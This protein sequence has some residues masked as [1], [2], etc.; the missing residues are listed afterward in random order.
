MNAEV[1]GANSMQ[2]LGLMSGTSLD[3]VD[4]ALLE[5]D[6]ESICAIG[7]SGEKKLPATL[8]N[9]CFAAMRIARSPDGH[10]SRERFADLDRAIAEFQAAAVSDF[11]AHNGIGP[12]PVAAVGFH[13]QTILHRPA[14]AGAIGETLQ[15]GSAQVLADLIEIPVVYDLRAA[16]IAAG[17]QGAPLAPV[18]HAA[19]VR[20]SSLPLPVA[21][22][23]L[24][25]VA[26]V[27]WIGAQGELFA[28]DT[29][30]ANGPLDQLT[31][32]HGL[33]RF[34][35]DGH[36]AASGKVDEDRI[37]G[38]LT[39]SYFAA[40]VPK[41]LD[42][43]DFSSD[44]VRDLSPPDGA[45]TLAAFAAAA[46]AHAL[47]LAPEMPAKLVVT[48]GG[49]YNPVIMEQLVERTTVPVIRAED[50][51]WLG[52]AIEAQ[53]WAFLAARHIR[54]LPITFPGT[55]GVRRPLSGGRLAVP[56]AAE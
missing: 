10:Y 12:A 8:R 36:L 32:G 4:I 6:G 39:H 33:G 46:V 23:N 31:L 20:W 22:L 55:T 13:G 51:G 25:G 30:P 2:V 41:S 40:F 54:G 11:L 9:Q 29:G 18:Y 45:A 52:D 48:G 34:D 53:A 21:V 1:V 56:N 27:S 14:R 7:P 37:K 49:R 50:V 26:N 38:W 28:F 5:T 16:D 15:A 44:L 24:G 35:Q 47:S 3:A 42:R 17:G 43:Y 19:L